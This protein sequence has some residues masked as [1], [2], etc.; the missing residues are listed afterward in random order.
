VREEESEWGTRQLKKGR[1]GDRRGLD[2]CC[3]HGVHGDA[4]VVR[5]QFG[6]D[7][8]DTRGPIEQKERASERAVA[9]MSGVR[10]I[11]REQARVCGGNWRQQLGTTGKQEGERAHGRGRGLSLIGGGH[12]S[13]DVGARGLAG[14]SWAEWA[15]FGF[16]FPWNFNAFSFYF[17]YRYEIKFKPNFKFKPIQTCASNK[18]IV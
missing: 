6:R 4:R 13:G 7:G 2:V 15:E 9:L 10:K 18:R 17:L 12:L 3:G 16:L 8:F 14:L 5:G 11:E 1:S